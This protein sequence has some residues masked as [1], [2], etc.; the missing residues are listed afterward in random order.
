MKLKLKLI[1][2]LDIRLMSAISQ[3]V[4]IDLLM[5][6]QLLKPYFRL[7]IRGALAIGGFAIHQ[8]GKPENRKNE[9]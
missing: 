2:G 5:N 4:G 8:T 9:G 6:E 3:L 7:L 1:P